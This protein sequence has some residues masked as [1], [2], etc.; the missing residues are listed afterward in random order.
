MVSILDT[1][2]HCIYAVSETVPSSLT[3]TPTHTPT[4]GAAIK[5]HDVV[6]IEELIQELKNSSLTFYGAT[7]NL[8]SHA[9][10]FVG[11]SI[12][13]TYYYGVAYTRTRAR[14]P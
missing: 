1:A 12:L 4:C 14:R 6:D 10:F 11:G 13:R 2:F 7:P 9:E 5:N 3:S 8:A